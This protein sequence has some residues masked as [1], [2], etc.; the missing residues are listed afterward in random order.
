MVCTLQKQKVSPCFAFS[1]KEKSKV[2][3]ERG[4]L[5]TLTFAR[6]RALLESVRFLQHTERTTYFDSLVEIV[7]RY[8][9]WKITA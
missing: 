6:W 1:N 7:S 2:T 4:K 9:N 8:V 3:E 5:I